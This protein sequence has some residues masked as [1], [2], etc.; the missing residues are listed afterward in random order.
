MTQHDLKNA[1]SPNYSAW[2]AASAGT[3]KTRLL[4]NRII[5]LLISGSDPSSILCLTFTKAAKGEMQSRISK[6]LSNFANQTEDEINAYFFENFG[7]NLGNKEVKS[8]QGFYKNYISSGKQV[9]IYTIHAFCQNLLQKFPIEAGIRPYFKVIDEIESARFLQK[10][11]SSEKI[12]PHITQILSDNLSI[13][14]IAEIVREL[15]E[16]YSHIGLDKKSLE[17]TKQVLADYFCLQEQNSL[18]Y[19]ADDL[20]MLMSRNKHLLQKIKSFEHLESF[21][22]PA[23]KKYDKILEHSEIIQFFLTKDFKKR[24]KLLPKAAQI[25]G[26]NEDELISM[27]D[28]IHEIK[29][30]KDLDDA[31]N[32]NH[33][34]L[35]LA[36]FAFDE[37]KKYKEYNNYLDYQDLIIYSYNLLCNSD[38]KEWIKYKLDGG[39]THILV[40]E[41]QDTSQEQWN[42]IIALLEDFFAGDTE[43]NAKTIFVVGD[44]KQSIYSFQGA[45]PDLFIEAKNYIKQKAL[46]AKVNFIEC[47]L[48]KTYR[49]PEHI[50]EFVH[51]TFQNIGLIEEVK[52]LECHNNEHF[53]TIEIW[54]KITEQNKQ[55]L[56]WPLPDGGVKSCSPHMILAKQIATYIRQTLD[57]KLYLDSKQREVSQSDFMILVQRRL[58]LNNLLYKELI[59][60]GV[61]ISGLDRMNLGESLIVQDLIATAKFILDPKDNLN[62]ACLLKSFFI[63]GADSDLYIV[64]N[65]KQLLE[66]ISEKLPHIYVKLEKIRQIYYSSRKKDF[67]QNIVGEFDIL[68]HLRDECEYEM[69]DALK[70]FLN[71]ISLLFSH[72]PSLGLGD[73]ADLLEISDISLKRDFSESNSVRITTIH[74]A[75]GLEAPIIILADSTDIKLTSSAKI[76]HLNVDA[77]L[78]PIISSKFKH[79]KIDEIKYM[80]KKESYNEY[81]RLLY[82]AITRTQDHLIIAGISKN[83]E[84][85]QSWH[86]IC[87]KS[88]LGIFEEKE[89]GRLVFSSKEPTRKKRAERTPISI[90]NTEIYRSASQKINKDGSGESLHHY[91]FENQSTIIGEK[92]H[93]AMEILVNTNQTMDEI[94]SSHYLSSINSSEAEEMRQSLNLCAKNEFFKYL[95]SLKKFAEQEVIVR[96]SDSFEIKRLDFV[97]FDEKTNQIYIVDYKSDR[98]RNRKQ[99][100]QEQMIEYK[101]A[102]AQIY[103][104][105]EILLYLFWLRE[106]EFEKLNV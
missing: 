86:D 4:T 20:T 45:R 58:I 60:L 30:A 83:N 44:V 14:S 98:L 69:Q 33:D 91:D 21:L 7:R 43:K 76:L 32:I 25:E 105:H 29:Y 47:H 100:Y 80:Q 84:E 85:Y 16:F 101:N 95:T 103:P 59:Q 41:S 71:E 64:K 97:A 102:L 23:P 50:F 87:T 28:I 106:N 36:C 48:Q 35:N 18:K 54:P 68:N 9:Q 37:Y 42:I 5:N 74:G 79:Q 90:T 67:F 63:R 72:Q 34:I 53:S 40:D 73:I 65:E 22:S 104:N 99:E 6:V 10:I 70:A 56:F 31:I 96:N 61:G 89:D 15:S 12:L 88:A 49:L 77:G 17:S 51:K 26:L 82:V 27:Q 55:D 93:K 46:G 2:I 78:V 13:F 75:K 24:K 8:V 11:I 39:I 19:L 94:L 38:I 3:G 1:T 52:K 62:L 81:L 66:K 57:S 92:F